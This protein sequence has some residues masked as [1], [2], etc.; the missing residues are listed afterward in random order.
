VEW[1]EESFCNDWKES[2]RLVTNVQDGSPGEGGDGHSVSG[3]RSKLGATDQVEDGYIRV[4]TI[5]C[6]AFGG[7][8]KC[9]QY[10]M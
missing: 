9:D 5:K 8:T 10:T 4:G 2:K 7:L 3:G 6:S 1:N